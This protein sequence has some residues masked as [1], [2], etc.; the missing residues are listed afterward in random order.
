MDLMTILKTLFGSEALTFDQFAEKLN[1]A[2]NLKLGN[3]I[4]FKK[5]LK[6]FEIP[7]ILSLSCHSRFVII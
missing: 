7:L 5:F 2:E 1:G 4:F 6:L 3:F